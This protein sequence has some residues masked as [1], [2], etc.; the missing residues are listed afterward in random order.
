MEVLGLQKFILLLY[1]VLFS[2]RWILNKLL[3]SLCLDDIQALV[4]FSFES[5]IEHPIGFIEYEGLQ[6]V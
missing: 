1:P 5:Q 2:D 3:L 4:H 6:V